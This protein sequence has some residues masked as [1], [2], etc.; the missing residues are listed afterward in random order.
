MSPRQTKQRFVSYLRV[1]TA[2]QGSAG[3]GIEAQRSTVAQHIGDRVLLQEYIEVESGK[4][5]ARPE[6]E[7][8]MSQA[9][10]TGSTLIIAKLDRLSRDAHFLT[11]L[12]KSK[13]DFVA[14]DLPEANKLTITIM[15]AVAEHERERISQRTKDA[16]RAAKARGTKLGNPN[17]AAHLKALGNDAAMAAVKAK[18]DKMARDYAAK[19]K[20]LEKAG[21]T[22]ARGIARALNGQ[23]YLTP[24]GG[25]WDAKAVIRLQVRLAGLTKTKAA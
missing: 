21:A 22:S 24:R 14:C 11:G 10:L 7:K 9:R 19:I 18:A 25:A 20:E 1:S 3:L 4:H 2:K 17:G 6:L 12:E 16:L 23:G 15:A 13:L 5:D 8:A